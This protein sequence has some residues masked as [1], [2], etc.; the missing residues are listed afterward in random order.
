V[1][2]VGLL[3]GIA[4]GDALLVIT[5]FGTFAL[6]I[7]VAGARM[8]ALAAQAAAE[9]WTADAERRHREA[10]AAANT[11]LREAQEQAEALSQLIVHDLR[12]PLA[13]VT[14]SLETM[15]EAL[16]PDEEEAQESA[17]IARRE[18]RRVVEM[19]N[20]LLL[21]GRLEAHR[22]EPLAEADLDALLLEVEGAGRA[23]AR[24]SGAELA[25]RRAPDV[26]RSAVIDPPLVRRMLDNLVGNACR[27]VRPSDHIEVAVERAGEA[28]RLAVRNTGSEVPAEVRD[29]LFE[30]HATAGKRDF[31][32]SGLGLYLCR[33]VAE[34]HGGSIALATRPGWGVS[35]EATFPQ[36]LRG[37]AAATLL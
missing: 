24:R 16:P 3:G 21:I 4:A 10:L 1:V 30:K 26:P 25:C 31:H 20:D 13:S 36:A 35:F 2:A 11:A 28:L 34:R 8:I 19:S 12:N 5:L 17:E 22:T 15:T 37:E 29:R 33:L 32:N 23:V 9:G 18:L 27:H 6:T 7:S 14:V